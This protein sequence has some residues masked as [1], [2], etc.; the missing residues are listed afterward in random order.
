VS[1]LWKVA[2]GVVG[3]LVILGYWGSTSEEPRSTADPV[4]QVVNEVEDAFSSESSG[5]ANAR[6]Q[7]ENYLDSQA[8]S[9][10]ASRAATTSSSPNR[11][12]S[13]SFGW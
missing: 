8:F 7:A 6:R 5:Q 2:L 12:I 13:V 10:A 4:T 3:A 1:N 11:G 9:R